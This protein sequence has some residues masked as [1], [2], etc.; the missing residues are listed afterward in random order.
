MNDTDGDEQQAVPRPGDFIGEWHPDVLRRLIT[1]ARPF[2]NLYFRSEV[3]DIDRIPAGGV[4]IVS[5]HSGGPFAQDVPVL[6]LGF[7]EKFGYDRP[8]Y[9]LGHDL[10][11]RGPAVPVV[12]RL[13]LIRA[14][15]D[16][17]VKALRAGAVVI[18][19]PG[20]DY[21]ALRPTAAQATID[22]D[23]RTG[24]VPTAVEAGVPIVPVVSIGGQ[25]TQLFLTRGRWLAKRL[26]LK[27]FTRSEEVSVTAG[28]PFGLS[29]GAMNMPLPSK[30]VTQ[31]LEP[32]DVTAE[33][34]EN[35]DI[36][37]VDEH[38][39]KVMQSAL[40]DLAAQRRFPVVG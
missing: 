7:F 16:N 28:F 18:V 17:A 6:W 22:F 19:F 39:R 40:D 20:G 13:G 34:G 15:R 38:V 12:T 37:A 35:P 27:R 8:I 25:E 1:L 23:G 36:A 29:V 2:Y 21:D 14:N 11:F 26:A 9:T 33:F 5:N 30:I 3:R 10:L 31:V 32:I 24:Y 4:L